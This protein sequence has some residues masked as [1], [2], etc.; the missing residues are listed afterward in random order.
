MSERVQGVLVVEAALLQAGD[1][2]PLV[3]FI[4]SPKA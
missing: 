4:L 3:E 1:Q 2:E